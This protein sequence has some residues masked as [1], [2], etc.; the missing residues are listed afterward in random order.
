MGKK[1]QKI[2]RRMVAFSSIVIFTLINL[3]FSQI[4]L[5]GGPVEQFTHRV[6]ERFLSFN[7][8]C[9][10]AEQY[11]KRPC[12]GRPC[13]SQCRIKCGFLSG[14]CPPVACQ[15]ANPGQCSGGGGGGGGGSRCPPGYTDIGRV[16]VESQQEQDD[17]YTLTGTTGAW[18]GLTDFL[19]EGEFGWTDGSPLTFTNFRAGQP[20]NGNNN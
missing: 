12:A 16:C 20:N 2:L 11:C 1:H 18:I 19:D 10:N 7:N 14:L 3:T 15:T 8:C 9:N 4:S 13:A 5:P 6:R 17:L